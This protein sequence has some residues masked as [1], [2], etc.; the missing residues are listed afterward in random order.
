MIL[1]LT[2][3][4]TGCGTSEPQVIRVPVEKL[5][6]EKVQ[7]PDELLADCPEP[8]LDT[9]ETNRDLELALGEAIVSLQDCNADKAQLREW[10]TR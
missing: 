9:L 7:A 5:V 10:Q 3:W 1:C 6:V 8:N 4:L 2:A